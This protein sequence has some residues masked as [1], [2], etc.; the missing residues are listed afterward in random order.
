MG[1]GRTVDS[2]DLIQERGIENLQDNCFDPPSVF[3]DVQSRKLVQ[4]R[5]GHLPLSCRRLGDPDSA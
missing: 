2:G 3:V 1:M 5:D 4:T